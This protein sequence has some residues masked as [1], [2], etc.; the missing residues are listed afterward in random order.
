[1]GSI[2]SI[3]NANGNILFKMYSSHADARKQAFRVHY[4][5]EIELSLILSGRGTYNSEGKIYTVEKGDMFFYKSSVQ[6]CITDIEGGGMEILNIHISPAYF[7]LIKSE[8]DTPHFGRDFLRRSFGTVKLTDIL[9]KEESDKIRKLI[10]EIKTEF[11]ERCTAFE[12][13]AESYLSEILVHLSRKMPPPDEHISNESS[14]IIF[15]V[16][17]YIDAHYTEQ[18]SLSSL[19][20]FARLEKT[21]FAAL[22]KKNL[23][24]NPWE[25]IL[26]KRIDK[27]IELLRITNKNVL[28]IA[29]ETGFNNTANFNKIFKK[30]TGMSPKE[31][32]KNSSKKA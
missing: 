29:G 6:H 15:K 21:Y 14:D 16:L 26:I 30:Y 1:M 13:L 32:R 11:C 7:H 25:Y 17:E 8:S 3:K 10:M 20:E 2:G 5:T 23:G 19:S 18:I 9:E 12:L 4:H 31:L 24:T 27:A 28:D 22:F